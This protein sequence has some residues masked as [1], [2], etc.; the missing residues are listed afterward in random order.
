MRK[1]GGANLFNSFF[2]RGQKT[3]DRVRSNSL[4]LDVQPLPQP[5]PEGFSGAVGQ[6]ELKST[7][8]PAQL[9]TGE[10]VTWTL[11]LSGTGN[12][13]GGVSAA[14]ARRPQRRPHAAAQTA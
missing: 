5:A 4:Q 3:S 13:P 10:P 1:F 11:T 12:W 2:S 7:L 8:A 14:G 9:K 6:F